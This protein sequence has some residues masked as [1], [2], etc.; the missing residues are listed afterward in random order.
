MAVG[1]DVF[2]PERCACVE[3]GW[4]W[5]APATAHPAGASPFGAEQLAGNV[6]EWVADRTE[7]GWRVVRGGCYLDHA[8]GVRA[9]RVRPADPER[10]TL[11]KGFGSRS[12]E[13]PV[14]RTL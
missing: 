8:W 12:K 4:G 11:T 7:D 9:S 13:E 5:T 10:A 14:T 2:D 1:R 6:W 3:A